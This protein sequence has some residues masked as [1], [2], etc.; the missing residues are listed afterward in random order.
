MSQF[1]RNEDKHFVSVDC[2]IF[3]FKE[4]AIHVL[5]IK[6]K[7]DP[8]KGE[9]SLM[10]GF[11]R[12]NESLNDTVSRVV[13]EY[14]GIEN[15]YWEQ[16]GAYGDVDRDI[17]E[18]VISIVYYALI[19]MEL[20]DETL[21][22]KYNAEWV[23]INAVGP[24]ILDHNQLLIDTL[25]LLRRRTATR[26]IGFNL[27]PEKFTLPQLQSLYEAIYQTPL[28]KRNFRKK[29]FEM[30]ILEKLDEKDK[31]ASKRGAYYYCFN[32]EKYDRRLEDGTVFS[33]I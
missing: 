22:K 1:Y 6:R 30:D 15:V 11:I 8:L 20:F 19:D 26:P 10:G 5:I 31:S 28:D 27:L 3:G 33:F 16:V 21:M 29:I 2:I 4:N 24:L 25:K 14:T 23:N 12:E 13:N 7:F 32:K 17:A 9:R 18:R